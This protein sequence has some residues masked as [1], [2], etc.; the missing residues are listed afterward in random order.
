MVVH[1]RL[2]LRHCLYVFF[3][4]KHKAFI[5]F[6]FSWIVNEKYSD[7][8]ALWLLGWHYEDNQLWLDLYGVELK[9]FLE[10]PLNLVL[11]LLFQQVWWILNYLVEVNI[12]AMLAPFVRRT[13]RVHLKTNFYAHFV[14]WRLLHDCFCHDYFWWRLFLSGCSL[15]WHFEP[16]LFSEA[17]FRQW[18]LL[19][20]MVLILFYWDWY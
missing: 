5:F 10:K 4:E 11:S 13:R 16:W 15:E 18:R 7:R 17:I 6:T 8:L 12:S 14:P 1:F 2:W 9:D 20:Y 3:C 19:D